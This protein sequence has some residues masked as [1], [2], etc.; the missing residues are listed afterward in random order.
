MAAGTVEN[1][2]SLGL[3]AAWAARANI[4]QRAVD[5]Q[6]TIDKARTRLKRLYPRV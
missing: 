6:V 4:K 1:G 2:F 3:L 5:W